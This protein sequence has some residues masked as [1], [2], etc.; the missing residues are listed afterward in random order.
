MSVDRKTL[1]IYIVYINVVLYATCYQLQ[2]PIEPFMVEK[3]GLTGD[4]S[5]E[6]AR[7]QVE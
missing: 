5:G 1:T 4:S 7:L 6:Y 2:R 3:L